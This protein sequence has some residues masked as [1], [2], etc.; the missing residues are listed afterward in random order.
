MHVQRGELDQLGCK[1]E[2]KFNA[3]TIGMC[4][5]FRLLQCG[6]KPE[7]LYISVQ[8]QLESE[9]QGSMVDPGFTISVTSNVGCF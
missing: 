3:L 8:T 6:Q 7:T 2:N 9:Y 1:N 4:H 5:H